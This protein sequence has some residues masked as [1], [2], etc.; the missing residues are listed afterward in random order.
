MKVVFEE[1]QDFI[2]RPVSPVTHHTESSLTN[3]LLKRF[4]KLI[5]SAKQA[6]ILMLIVSVICFII[7]FVSLK[8]I[9]FP[10]KPSPVPPSVTKIR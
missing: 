6:Q 3:F 2:K 5:Y 8:G 4:P 7:M 9:V 1:E 10:E